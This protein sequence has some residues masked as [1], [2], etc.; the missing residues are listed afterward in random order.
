[1]IESRPF[2]QW[3]LDFIGVI[4]PP[5]SAGHKFI[6]TVTD[7][8]TRWTEATYCKFSTTEVVIKFLEENIITRFGMP[9]SLVCDNGPAFSSLKFSKWAFEYG[10]ILRFSSNYYPQGNGLAEST[11]KILLDIIKRLIAKSPREWN[12]LLRYALWVD[13]TKFKIALGSTP[14]HLVYGTNPILPVNL[15]IPT[16]KFA[17]ESLGFDNHR[18]ARIVQMLQLDEKRGQAI[19]KF[20]KHQ[21][22]VKRWFDKRA[23]VKTFRISN[24]VLC[25]DKAHEK[26]GSH[27]KFDKLWLGPL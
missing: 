20:A 19:K 17:N 22:V 1:M 12:T 25:W 24:L 18:E 5:S 21:V 8:C 11:N 6:L 16:W 4:N 13:R 10:I 23:R 3:D 7:Y 27:G 15:R 14:Y 2:A 9:Y 26:K